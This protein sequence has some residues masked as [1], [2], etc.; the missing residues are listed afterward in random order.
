MAE[1]NTSYDQLM[2]TRAFFF[3][4]LILLI[5]ITIVIGAY[6]FLWQKP[7]SE[8][9]A[10]ERS[11]LSGSLSFDLANSVY[12]SGER[13][14]GSLFIDPGVEKLFYGTFMGQ[15]SDDIVSRAV[16]DIPGF[17]QILDNLFDYMLLLCYRF[18]FFIMSMTYVIFLLAA[19]IVHGAIT[20]HRKRYEFGD[21][22]IL[23]NL[24]ARTSLS[25]AIPI[26]FLIWSLPF[27]VHPLALAFSMLFCLVGMA[28]FVFSMPKLA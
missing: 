28:L 1:S 11:F 23:M 20:R 22:P 15:Q 3:I 4:A 2:P 5:N 13:L 7:F 6:P 9:L 24:W 8:V 21:T 19:V 18:G 16:A 14:Y 17:G 26:T 10:A 25:Y 27:A 12:V